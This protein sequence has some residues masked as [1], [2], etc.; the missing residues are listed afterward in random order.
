MTPSPRVVARIFGVCTT[1]RR[2]LL[3]SRRVR[4]MGHVD[5]ADALFARAME[6][7]AVGYPGAAEHWGAR[8]RAALE[9][10]GEP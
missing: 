10:M 8:R 1:V 5:L 2:S 9:R 3:A 6:L 4:A 7:R